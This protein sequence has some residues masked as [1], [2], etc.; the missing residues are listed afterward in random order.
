MTAVKPSKKERPKLHINSRDQSEGGG[1]GGS[2]KTSSVLVC[3]LSNNRD[4][5]KKKHKSSGERTGRGQ[6]T[7]RWGAINHYSLKKVKSESPRGV[8][9]FMSLRQWRVHGSWPALSEVKG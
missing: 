5:T 2:W 7:V 6:E 8:G 4:G 9:L 1:G 3:M